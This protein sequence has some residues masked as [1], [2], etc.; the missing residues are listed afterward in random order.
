MV[1]AALFAEEFLLGGER[2][3]PFV[4]E[5]VLVAEVL[6]G[7]MVVEVVVNVVVDLLVAEEL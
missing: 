2:E 6:E 1:R 4:W 5:V 3:C 7:E